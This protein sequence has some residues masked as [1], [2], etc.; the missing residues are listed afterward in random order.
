[1]AY[2]NSNKNKDKFPWMGQRF[3]GKKKVRKCFETKKEAL[4]WESERLPSPAEQK[5]LT[6]SLLEWATEYLKHAEQNFTRKTFDEK[7]IAFRQFF[8]CLGI[9]PTGSVHLL[10]AYQAQ[11]ALQ[12]QTTARSGNAANKDRKNLS[13]AWSWGVKFLQLPELNPFS[14]VEKFASERHERHIPTLDDFWKVFHTVED[15]QDK[16]M[17]YCYLQTGARRDEVFRLTW[18]D[19]DFFRK[20]IRLS[21]RKN[22]IGEWRSQWVSVKDDLIEWLLRHRKKSNASLDNVFVSYRSLPYEYRQHWLKI[23]CE[24]AGVEPFGFHGIRHLF[25]SIL[26]AENVPLVEI[27]FMLRHT[28]LATTQRYIHR[29]KKENR[30]VLAALPG[31]TDSEKSTSEVHQQPFRSVVHSAN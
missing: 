8:S 6:V 5:T 26:A 18:P 10:T 14:K 11:K 29:L 25:A 30:E 17:L 13:A 19:V 15:D 1:M 24:K 4:L 31:L 3:I 27:Q 23:L 12:T 2:K 20:R 9:R 21:W 7:R 28:S 16:L 22:K